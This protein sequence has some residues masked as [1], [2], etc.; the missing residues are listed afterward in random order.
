MGRAFVVSVV[1]V[2]VVLTAGWRRS[3]AGTRPNGG[4]GETAHIAGDAIAGSAR[5]GGAWD[6]GQLGKAAQ[7][8]T[9]AVV[10]VQLVV[11]YGEAQL[12]EP[13]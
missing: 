8:E 1:L 7:H 3:V 6:D 9:V 4:G 13:T 5:E 11:R 2:A 12:R 10:P